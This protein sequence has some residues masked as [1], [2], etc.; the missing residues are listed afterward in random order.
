MDSSV[1]HL[2]NGLA[3]RSTVADAIVVGWA[4]FGPAVLIT[5]VGLA[6]TVLPAQ[7][8]DLMPRRLAL[9]SIAAAVLAL[10]LAQL[11][12]H[13]WF[14]VRPYLAIP[15]HLLV[16]PSEDASFPSDHAV[17]AFALATP[18]LVDSRA[19]RF[20]GAVLAGAVALALA[21]VFVGIHYPSDVLGGAAIGSVV[22]L[23]V[24]GMAV[25]VDLR[26]PALWAPA[27]GA[28]RVTDRLLNAA[29]NRRRIA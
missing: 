20:G 10:G 1:F 6:W 13:E 27:R 14:R 25:V 26:L 8:R 5:L 28:S 18:L 2:V 19:R 15:T 9:I 16:P 3:G 23:V 11:I 22:A 12:G 24:A 17:G 7:G 21:R 29:R 4:K